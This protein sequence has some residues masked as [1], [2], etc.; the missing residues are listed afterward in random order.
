MVSFLVHVF[1]LHVSIFGRFKFQLILWKMFPI[2][3]ALGIA[4][5]IFVSLL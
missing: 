4:L 1:S 3:L 5:A 2:F